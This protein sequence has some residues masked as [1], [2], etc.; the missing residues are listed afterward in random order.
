MAELDVIRRQDPSRGKT[1]E[2]KQRI[3]E[4]RQ[5]VEAASNGE[6][7]ASF[8]QLEAM[9]AVVECTLANQQEKL[10]N[11]YVVLA[12]VGQSALVVSPT[13]DEI[14][15]VNE[16]VRERL[17]AEGLISKRERK[18]DALQT[19]D[20]TD[21]QKTRPAVLPRECHACFPPEAQRH[22]TGAESGLGCHH[23]TRCGRRVKW[24]HPYCRHEIFESL[25]GV[26]L[27][28][29]CTFQRTNQ[30]CWHKEP[31][32]PAV[33]FDLEKGRMAVLPCLH[34]TS[35]WLDSTEE[36]DLFIAFQKQT[37]EWVRMLPK[38]HEKLLEKE[39]GVVTSI[40]VRELPQEEDA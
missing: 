27:P 33:R 14:N 7:A 17:Q 4:Y 23:E 8:S 29:I 18:V 15:R 11:E 12:K 5:A 22:R 39:S 34:F 13:W 21:A 9:G 24:A 25:H 31:N 26:P 3:D 16:Q 28:A 30:E 2:E 1:D 20:L 37:V 35:A 36:E 6:I 32:T 10:A 40:E 38:R 19:V